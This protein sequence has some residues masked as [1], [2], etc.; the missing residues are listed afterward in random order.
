MKILIVYGTSEGQTRKIARFMENVLQNENHQVVIADSTEDPPLPDDFDVVIIGS[1]IH[2][3][4]YHNS[5]QH[6][7]RKHLDQLNQKPS[8]FFSVCLAVASNIKEEHE[9]A[10]AIARDFLKA[11][12]WHPTETTHIAGALKYTQYDYFKRLVMRMIAKKEGGDTDVSKDH[13]Y[14]DWGAVKDFVLA[15]VS[16]IHLQE[17]L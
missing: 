17:N 11:T 3:H 15:F 1:S 13:E 8:A 4:K 6:Y 5:I 2:M 16:K 9:E 10:H 7:I 12:N 14:T